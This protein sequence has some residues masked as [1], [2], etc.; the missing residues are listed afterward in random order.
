MIL[1][2]RIAGI[3]GLRLRKGWYNYAG[4]CHETHD[5]D[6]NSMGWRA[7]SS[8]DG[9]DGLGVKCFAGC[10]NAQVRETLLGILHGSKVVPDI[11]TER[12]NAQRS[13]IDWQELWG[14]S[15][16]LSSDG[17][18]PARRFITTWTRPDYVPCGIR[19]VPEAVKTRAGSLIVPV[20]SIEA[21]RSAHPL[22]VDEPLGVQVLRIGYHGEPVADAGGQNKRSYGVIFGGVFMLGEGRP[23][24]VAEGVKDCMAINAWGK[25]TTIC[26]MGT[27][28]MQ[29]E[30]LANWL[31]A[32]AT[33]IADND[34]KGLAAA[35]IL[36]SR[37]GATILTPPIEGVD[38]AEWLRMKDKESKEGI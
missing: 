38:I 21:W 18:H 33:I 35:K 34:V 10:D 8:P 6:S 26:T 7:V 16:P 31:P 3:L 36:G 30:T 4:I 15:V 25:G 13:S 37:T 11:P 32:T 19:W 5:R 29:S 24:F 9:R 12:F 20:A 2:D 1:A 27:G 28:G 22:P 23:L 17:D 14:K